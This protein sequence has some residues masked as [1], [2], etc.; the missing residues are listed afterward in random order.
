MGTKDSVVNRRTRVLG[1]G[2]PVLPLLLPLLDEDDDEED[3]S[4]PELPHAVA[5]SAV[6]AAERTLVAGGPEDCC[7]GD[8]DDGAAALTDNM[9]AEWEADCEVLLLLLKTRQ[10]CRSCASDLLRRVGST[11]GRTGVPLLMLTAGVLA[12]IGHSRWACRC[13]ARAA[14]NCARCAE[15]EFMC[16]ARQGGGLLREKNASENDRASGLSQAAHAVTSIPTANET[17]SADKRVVHVLLSARETSISPCA[18]WQQLEPR[19]ME[20][21]RCGKRPA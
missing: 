13:I 14:M 1:G 17:P 5:I 7:A 20:E 11:T 9:P 21:Q 18:H 15:E 3:E 2:K 4:E 10:G 6:V 8:D 12:A 19:G 16:V